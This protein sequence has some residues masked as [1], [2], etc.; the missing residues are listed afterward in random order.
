MTRRLSPSASVNGAAADDS[1]PR[2]R[3]GAVARMVRMPAATLRVWERRYAVTAPATT[4][5]GQRLYSAADVRR[6]ALL[7]QLT[8]VG[9]A[10]GSLAAMDM[11]TLQ[12]VAA[13]HVAALETSPGAVPPAAGPRRIG[14]VGAVLLHR[15]KRPSIQ[16]R[17]GR[18]S[19]MSGAFETIEQALEAH[20][21]H[22]LDLL[23]VHSP[24]LPETSVALMRKAAG[25]A[26]AP[27]LAVVYAFA[28][29]SC[30]EMLGAAGVALFREPQGDAAL[31]AWLRRSDEPE[32]KSANRAA[33]GMASTTAG[34][35]TPLAPLPAD[36]GRLFTG[37]VPPRRYDDATLADFATLSTTIACECPQHVAEVLMQLSYFEAYSAECALRSPADAALHGYL[38][39]VAG[40]SRALFEAAL[41]HVALHEGLTLTV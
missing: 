30:C 23:L 11:A 26:A 37:T 41:E 33:G 1:V 29:T 21:S 4:P 9:H 32:G 15:L 22:P 6:L 24:T 40:A 18:P 38:Q 19:A 36:A 13:N 39:H 3:T 27:Q 14:V 25:R 12:G 10:I 20:A 34:Q 28:T 8:G 31:A 2:H 17:L 16:R 35:R 5:S 7:K